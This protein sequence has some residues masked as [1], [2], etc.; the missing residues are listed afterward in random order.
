MPIV[1]KGCAIKLAD[2][3]QKKQ[4]LASFFKRSEEIKEPCFVDNNYVELA[5]SFKDYYLD[6]L[7]GRKPRFFRAINRLTKG[8]C[9]RKYISYKYRKS[10]IVRIA[11][12]I[13]CE[14]HRELLS[15]ALQNEYGVRLSK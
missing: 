7:A 2:D 11:N 14:A 10:N 8:Y 12:Y 5:R 9:I 13:D 4:I 15:Q 6:A 3:E 1:K